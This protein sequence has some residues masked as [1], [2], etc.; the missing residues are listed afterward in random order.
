MWNA[1][2]NGLITLSTSQPHS[3]S[4]LFQSMMSGMFSQR[5]QLKIFESVIQLVA[6]DVMHGFVPAK[7]PPNIA[8]H[9][10]AMLSYSPTVME[11]HSI[12]RDWFNWSSAIS[13]RM[14]TILGGREL[15]LERQ[16]TS[17][18]DK[19]QYCSHGLKHLAMCSASG[20]GILAI[21]AE[22]C[23]LAALREPCF[24]QVEFGSLNQSPPILVP[25][26]IM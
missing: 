5:N 23:F 6:I 25:S 13:T 19:S 1:S 3:F 12:T 21:C 9:Y 2:G 14:R 17:T 4:E 7:F 8:L 22:A 18:T 20:L 15:R 24:L 26:G 11:R 16:S 10:S